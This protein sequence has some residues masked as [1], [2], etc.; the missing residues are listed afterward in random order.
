MQA[1]DVEGDYIK[2]FPTL[3]FYPAGKDKKA[4]KIMYT[5]SRDFNSIKTWIDEHSTKVGKRD[6]VKVDL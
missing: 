4:N 2:K 1:N 5:G 3:I 6:A